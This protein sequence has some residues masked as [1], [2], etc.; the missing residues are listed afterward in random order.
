MDIQ[1][2]RRR[3]TPLTP[4]EVENNREYLINKENTRAIHSTLKQKEANLNE[5]QRSS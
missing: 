4:E 2:I 3:L 1:Y 5:K